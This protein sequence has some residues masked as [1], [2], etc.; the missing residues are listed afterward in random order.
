M[1][2]PANCTYIAACFLAERS[3]CLLFTTID[4]II[5][6]PSLRDPTSPNTYFYE[7]QCAMHVVCRLTVID[8]KLRILVLA[9][10][11]PDAQC[12]HTV[13]QCNARFH[14]LPHVGLCPPCAP[15]ARL[16]F[17]S[18]TSSELVWLL[19]DVWSQHQH[20]QKR[21]GIHPHNRGVYKY[22]Q[23]RSSA[24]VCYN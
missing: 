4:K 8:L 12:P 17:V 24:R 19:Q 16:S 21:V 5:R 15:I 3:T 14:D 20:C 2:T 9:V 22:I 18:A 6:C 10:G 1:I 7:Q 13:W 23:V 11:S